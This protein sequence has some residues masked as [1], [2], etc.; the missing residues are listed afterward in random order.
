MR[1]QGEPETRTESALRAWECLAPETEQRQV[2]PM[3]HLQLPLPQELP[4]LAEVSI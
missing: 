1:H 2:K 4:M 3:R